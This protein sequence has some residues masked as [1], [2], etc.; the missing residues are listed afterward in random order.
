MAKCNEGTE[1]KQRFSSNFKVLANTR[2]KILT[3]Y[4]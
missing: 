1:L 3:D 2:T 4:I